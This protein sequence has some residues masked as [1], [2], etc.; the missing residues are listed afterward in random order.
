[1]SFETLR[2]ARAKHVPMVRAQHVESSFSDPHKWA[3]D[4]MVK[5]EKQF[6]DWNQKPGKGATCQPG[7]WEFPGTEAG[8]LLPLL[9]VR[10]LGT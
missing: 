7:N 1:M 8:Q 9:G 3:L 10:A 2:A 4:W 5:M 6:N